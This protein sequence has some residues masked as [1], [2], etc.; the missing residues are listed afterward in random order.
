MGS[1]PA[2]R[3][4]ARKHRRE[5]SLGE[6]GQGTVVGGRYRIKKSIG[7]GGVCTVHS[8]HDEEIDKD[9]AVKLLKKELV[10]HET[11]KA[12][13]ER[14]AQLLAG[15][16]DPSIVLVTDYGTHE[17]RPYLVM[18]LLRGK[19]LHQRMVEAPPP[20]PLVFDVMEQL[21][22]GLS[23]I[24]GAGVMH[25][26]LKP[27]NLF[28]QSKG[29]LKIL[30]FGFAR[31]VADPVDPLQRKEAKLT[32][33]GTAFGTP[34]YMSP[35]QAT[36]GEMDF[37]TDL[38]AVGVLLFELLAGK[39]PFRGEA[40]AVLRQHITEPVPQLEA[41][42]KGLQVAPQLQALIEKAMAKSKE[43]RYA[44]ADE[45]LAAL[46]EL[47]RPFVLRD[48]AKP[49]RAAKKGKASAG[50]E[51]DPTRIFTRDEPPKVMP[52]PPASMMSKP[53]EPPTAAKTAKAAK[54]AK[55]AKAKKPPKAPAS[56]APK[57]PAAATSRAPKPPTAATSRAP[58]PP[59][60]PTPKSASKRRSNTVIAAAPPPPPSSGSRAPAP[61]QAAAKASRASAPPPPQAAAT[62]SRAPAPPPSQSM[63]VAVAAF[64]DGDLDDARLQATLEEQ[65]KGKPG[66]AR[67]ARLHYELGLIHSER[68]QDATGAA[69]HFAEAT[70]LDPDHLASARAARR[71][72]V[73]AGKHKQALP[74]FD[75]EIRLHPQPA[76]RAR[77]QF[78]KGRLIESSGGN[79]ADA[80][81]AYRAG[82]DLD[83]ADRD[84]LRA[85]A[86][87]EYT[88]KDWEA[89]DATLSR[90][91]ALAEGDHAYRA[92]LI[93]RR[94]RIADNRSADPARAAE[95]YLSAL[96]LDPDLPGA[97]EALKRSGRSRGQWQMWVQ[98][99]EQEA[100][101]STDSAVI[102]AAQATIAHIQ[103]TQL[104][105]PEAATRALEAAVAQASDDRTL[106]MRLAN[107]HRDCARPAEEAACLQRIASLTDEMPQRVALHYRIGHL[108]DAQLND[109]AQAL[110]HYSA[111]LT[112]D[113][114]H[115]PSLQAMS[116]MHRRAGNWRGL[117]EL[118]ELELSA[119]QDPLQR[120]EL[121]ARI[122]GLLEGKLG[123]AEAAVEQL[124]TTLS[125]APDHEGA[126]RELDRILPTLGRF[127]ELA[128]VYEQLLD[129]APN[130]AQAINHL[131]RI[132]G[133]REDR[134]GDAAGAAHAY[135]R[136][137]A[138]EPA[139][140]GALHA[141]QRAA[142]RAGAH[143]LLL[144]ALDL[145]LATLSHS[146]RWAALQLRA[147][148][149]LA[150]S[151]DD[152]PA[153][154]ERV[155]EV[156]EA[157]PDTPGA[158]DALGRL[159]ARLQRWDRLQD[160][161]AAQLKAETSVG[162]QTALL[163]RMGLL[164]EDELGK[165]RDAMGYHARALK[166][167]PGYLPCHDALAVLQR[168]AGEW[169]A[170]STTLEN[171]A[172]AVSDPRMKAHLYF[173]IGELSEDALKDPARA[174]R[175][176]E[177]ALL[178]LPSFRPATDARMRLLCDQRRHEDL[179]RALAQE[180]QNAKDPAV[181][182][183]ATMRGA[184][185]QAELLD[186]AK[187]AAATYEKAL[188]R[189][190]G[191]MSALVA[192]EVLYEQLSDSD[193]LARVYHAQVAG[194]EGAEPKVAVLRDLAKVTDGEDRVKIYA[195]LVALDP[196]DR[197]AL[198]ALAAAADA[199]ADMQN[200][201]RY[202]GALAAAADDPGVAAEHHAATAARMEGKAPEHA[203]AA[204]RTALA[205]DPT[206]VWSARGVT[207][208]ARAL[209]DAMALSQAAA[210]EAELTGDIPVAVGLY[211][212]ASSVRRAAG[213]A[214]EAALDIQHALDLD[215]SHV[216][217]AQQ[218]TTTL[219]GLGE[220]ARL[221]D[222]LSRAAQDGTRGADLYTEVA[223]LRAEQLQDVPEAIATL[224]RALKCQAHH[225]AALTLMPGYLETT[226][227]WQ[228]AVEAHESLIEHRRDD[229]Q[230]LASHLAAARICLQRL[231][232][233]HAAERHLGKALAKD[234]HN[235]TALRLK[236]R[237]LSDQG[238][239][240]E[241]LA[242]AQ[243]LL[244]DA[245]TPAERVALL[246][247]IARA[248]SRIGRPR[249]SVAALAQAVAIEGDGGEAGNAYR[250]V[251]GEHATWDDYVVALEGHLSTRPDPAAAAATVLAIADAQAQGMRA[252]KRALATLEGGVR[253]FPQ[254]GALWVA[255]GRQL[256][257]VGRQ[258]DA[259]EVFRRQ[260]HNAPRNAALWRGLGAAHA[261]A[262]HAE[263]AISS[264][265]PLLLLDAASGE[266]LVSLR[267]REPKPRLSA[268]SMSDATIGAL[269]EGEALAS[270]LAALTRAMT[271]T[272]LGKLHPADLK[273]YGVTKRDKLGPQSKQKAR[274]LG[275]QIAALLGLT[276]F[277]LY[278][279][280]GEDTRV[281]VEL[282]DPPALMIPRAMCEG[283]ASALV[284]SLCTQM[285]AIAQGL[286]ALECIEP[287]ALSLLLGGAIRR[288]AAGF[289]DPGND[290]DALDEA[291]RAVGKALP[292]LGRGPLDE[293]T[294]RFDGTAID[295]GEWITDARRCAERA[296]LLVSD[297]LLSALEQLRT[298]ADWAAL[299]DPRA[300]DL[301]QFW[302]GATAVAHRAAD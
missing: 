174:L 274:K 2:R 196:K 150:D 73:A 151:I 80:L 163:H 121:H 64:V 70:R 262:G 133:L 90:L 46:R 225:P 108:L 145:E 198:E 27:G 1:P 53:P 12:R 63:A 206:S 176:H 255:Y 245:D 42:A 5:A 177:Q 13:F 82:L 170:L 122:A 202:R 187:G 124:R 4:A 236:T 251:I 300:L 117:L 130:G 106:L 204:Y 199:S 74:L 18:E 288:H 276:E 119:T 116:A 261:A 249:E 179:G 160:V 28:V 231:D 66:K 265:L 159:Y 256:S 96:V 268:G 209:G 281:R 9:V 71:A 291:A 54:P 201:V 115:R 292:W 283:D 17:D 222:L 215:P 184:A 75:A 191:H 103:A 88:Q 99:L 31:N 3:R 189:A 193:A 49:P 87:L 254:D 296:A 58:A 205:L 200:Y 235:P 156:V 232:D 120:A 239:H 141:M 143:A 212:E 104:N 85:V 279:H 148:D 38:Y 33:A 8:A 86:R 107:L 127:D 219:L 126:R 269:D 295:V 144:R 278:L 81:T 77:L 252:P 146:P 183:D 234:P 91:A 40:P 102:S 25:R 32:V 230:R 11:L 208:C 293:A 15:L 109:A 152:A 216:Q 194:L 101:R 95:L 52:K 136:I 182:L 280:D 250:A 167:D 76:A 243:T 258:D 247:E 110:H 22:T 237:M 287:E 289:T 214:A 294:A 44:S 257:A 43:A 48:G 36:V 94:A 68:L 299:D 221:C 301:L 181:A 30:D 186:D 93:A 171:R 267:G 45:M 139:H 21:L 242:V 100:A 111:A 142:A 140:L 37:R 89:L 55:A 125:L 61:P 207:R 273:R 41:V 105:S 260:I 26:D 233:V 147:A 211:L 56:R 168:Q 137:L 197:E 155:R 263:E 14:E 244:E 69:K 298:G 92:A 162:A 217:A 165:P 132:G 271:T 114:A 240:D 188:Q 195:Q 286:S 213:A 270:S 118:H 98:S 297:D 19:T 229:E 138:I 302:T 238:K 67:A 164:A 153:A 47:P 10:G 134:L 57:P 284:F 220:V 218:L 190:P 50:E 129:H 172:S 154:V 246:L 83:S 158:L 97:I 7:A 224:E 253:D 6:F 241:A 39:P 192:L 226:G 178:A 223:R 210:L 35:E 60:P 20:E 16:S 282:L 275:N 157:L 51:E 272:V 62:A 23:A 259:V 285:F 24:H 72:L 290:D 128:Q 173:E 227:Q 65:L 78:D 180:A 228:R 123:E 79:N 169:K 203:L 248:Q 185:V 277:D 135:E 112:L 29:P 113:G 175:A 149:V 34:S 166:L 266:Q 161:H 131:F 84:L 59:T 264:A